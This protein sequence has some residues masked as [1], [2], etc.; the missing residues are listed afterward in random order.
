MTD[1]GGTIV[2][3]VKLVPENGAAAVRLAATHAIS[4]GGARERLSNLP[5][6]EILVTNTLPQTR[7]PKIRCLDIV[8]LLPAL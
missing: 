1:T 5:I 8:P 3:A 6:S 4:S 7:H 2:G